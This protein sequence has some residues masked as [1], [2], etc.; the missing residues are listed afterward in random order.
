MSTDRAAR[1][2]DRMRLPVLVV[3]TFAFAGNAFA[4]DAAP[5]APPAVVTPA[6]KI[7]AA[8]DLAFA[9]REVA[10]VYEK[11]TGQHVDLVLGSTGLLA[12][13]VQEGAPFDVL[14]AANVSFV[15][16]VVKA[17]VCDGKTKAM[18][19]QGRIVMWSS[20]ALGL[21]APADVKGL[22]DAKVKKIA[23][24]NPEHA[25]YG[26]AAM[27]A[28]AKAGVLDVVKPK[29]VYGENVQQT[30][31]YAQTGNVEVAIVALSLAIATPDGDWHAIDPA[32]HAP[33][34]QAL[35]VCG[36]DAA[37]TAAARGFT[38]FVSSPDGR[39]IMKR[40]GFVLPG[41]S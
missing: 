18:Y 4:A 30:L 31:K 10:A 40:Y 28:I 27:E 29:L 34:D 21:A 32:L 38:T 24:A 26:K 9:F 22:A 3:A 39:S 19:A 20:K 5:A 8:A 33:I 15:D 35:V 2:G 13:Q 17:G 7:A 14:A 36:K 1:Y 25:P 6:L 16:D 12:K 23:I 11:K 41:E 37:R